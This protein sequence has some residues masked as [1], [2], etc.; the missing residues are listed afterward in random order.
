V[1]SILVTGGAGFIGSHVCRHLLNEKKR[2]VVL[3]DL[4]GGSKANLPAGV[5]FVKGSVTDAALIT[6]LFKTHSF[7]Y[8]FHLAAY[9]AESRSHFVRRFNYENNL[10]GSA[11]LINAAVNFGIKCFVFCSSIA[12]Y[13]H[14]APPVTEALTPQP[15]DPYGIAKYA[16]ELD[17]RA[18][19]E[20]FGLKHIIFRPHNV[21]GPNQNLNDPDRNVIGIFM[22]QLL[23]GEALTIVG[24]GEQRRG[25]SYIDDVA[26]IIARSIAVP[27]AINETFNLGSDVHTSINELANAVS[28]AMDMEA[29]R[30]FLPARNEVFHAYSDHQ[31]IKRAFELDEATP[32]P[33]SKGLQLMAAWAKKQALPSEND[34]VHSL[35]NEI[36]LD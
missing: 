21:Y 16:I 31:K 17:L 24:D 10:L 26:P 15:I 32:T 8:V 19:S 6:E 35:K 13:G 1:D 36:N 27:A 28:V 20:A 5:T 9:A 18:A 30:K 7:D 25:F 33:L 29:E 3:D 11:N 2:L 34:I 12:V 4:S 22:R 23:R 14:H